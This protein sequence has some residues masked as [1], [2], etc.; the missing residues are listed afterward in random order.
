MKHIFIISILFSLACSSKTHLKDTTPLTPESSGPVSL[1]IL[2]PQAGEVVSTKDVPVSF[3]LGN[4]HVE[5][6]GQHI[7]LIIDNEAYQPVYT[8]AEPY[9]LKN[10]KPGAHT[11]RAFPARA[12]HESIKDPAAFATVDFFVKTKKPAPKV[13]FNKDPVL[14]YSRPKGKYE[15]EKADKI[16][17]D[18]WVKNA[19]L[20]NDGYKVRYQ[21]DNEKP[22]VLAEWKPSFF[23]HLGPGK[24]KLH[25]VLLDKK[26]RAV[27]GPFNNTTREFEVV[28]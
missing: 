15:G 19:D 24:H 5:P 2:S 10:L 25:I 18:F 23:E 9:V 20:A 27:K 11:I 1:K 26:G 28:K 13:D 4:Y 22:K 14:T 8:V 6:G 21:L 7:H 17:F 3:K 12:W 16:L